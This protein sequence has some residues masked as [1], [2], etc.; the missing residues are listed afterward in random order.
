MKSHDLGR[1]CSRRCRR[2]ISTAAIC[3]LLMADVFFGDKHRGFAPT[4]T[5]LI[6]AGGAAVTLFFANVD[7]R[8]CCSATATWPTRSPCCSN[9]SA[10]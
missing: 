10:S 9:Y 1:A 7:D 8:T 5:L 2:S 4:L 6:L 3:V